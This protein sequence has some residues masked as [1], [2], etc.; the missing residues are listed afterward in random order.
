[1]F[2]YVVGNVI[3]VGVCVCVELC[4]LYFDECEFCGDEEV[5]EEYEEVG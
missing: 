5:V 2:D 4:W 1:M 3:M